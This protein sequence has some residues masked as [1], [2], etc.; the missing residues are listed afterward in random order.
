MQF[1]QESSALS[2]C[3]SCIVHTHGRWQKRGDLSKLRILETIE[4]KNNKKYQQQKLKRSEMYIF[5][6]TSSIEALKYSE[7]WIIRKI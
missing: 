2:F 6:I 3:Y 7:T 4:V 5:N 1:K